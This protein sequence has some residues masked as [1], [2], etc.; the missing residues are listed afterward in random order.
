LARGARV[1]A[2]YRDDAEL[3]A[4]REALTEQERAGLTAVR[5]D[6]TREDDVARL[7]EAAGK[8]EVVIHLVGGFALAPLEQTTL[9]LWNTQF[10]LNVTSA[11]LVCKHAVGPMRAGG[12]GRIVTVGSRAAVE[13]T[14]HASAYAASKA[15]LVALTRVV[16]DELRGLDATANCVLPSVIDTPANRSALPKANFASWVS[17][18][19]LADVIC[20]LGSHAAVDLR[21]AAVPVY[22]SA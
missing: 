4:A 18:S 7:Y 19:S 13:P 17:P 10:A 6:V 8:I 20:F 22:G 12:Y 1:T 15:A 21:G 3:S 16:A 14:A 9:D 5:A 2:S 11:F